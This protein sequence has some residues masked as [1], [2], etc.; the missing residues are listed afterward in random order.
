MRDIA[1]VLSN[2]HLT[3]PLEGIKMILR[4]ESLCSYPISYGVYDLINK[5]DCVMKDV[6]M[7]TSQT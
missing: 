5:G 1:R 3:I 7:F 2:L 4:G 6:I